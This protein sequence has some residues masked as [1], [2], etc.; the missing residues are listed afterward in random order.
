[1]QEP[2]PGYS[3]ATRLRAGTR[4]D[5]LAALR[6]VRARTLALADAWQ[7][8]LGPALAVPLRDQLNPPL[9]EWGHVAWFQEWWTGRSRQR[10]LGIA[11][12]PVHARGASLLPGADELYDSSEVPHD[13]RWQLPLPG[14]GATRAYLDATLAQAL[15]LLAALPPDAGDDAL[16]FFRLAAL[17]EAMHAEA[18]VYMAATLDLDLGPAATVQGPG[19]ADAQRLPPAGAEIDVPAQAFALGWQGP[20]FAFDNE[21]GAHTVA[22]QA[23]RIDAHPVSWAAYAGFLA[24]GGPLDRRWWD[25]DGWAWLQ[26][27]G[28][29][30]VPPG[31]DPAAPALRLSAWEAEAWCRWAGRRLPTEAEWE[32]AA[33]TAT[34]FRWG[35]AW[36][37]TAS[38]FQPYPGFQPHPYRDYSQPW[39]GSRRVLRGAGPA[40]PPEIAHPRYRNFFEPRRNDVFAGFRSCAVAAGGNRL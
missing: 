14:P 5:V 16:Y 23:F 28:P 29:R 6:S 22:L 10:G 4:D 26:R 20:G 37:W 15:D 21:L 30:Q 35:G 18:A 33:L 34:G 38:P 9:W 12:D 8:A 36:E 27:A 32:C 7:A 40:T 11:C 2:S 39:F 13:A 3:P 25:E 1:M 24:D 31:A 19:Q 17:H